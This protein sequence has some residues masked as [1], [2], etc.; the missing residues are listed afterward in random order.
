[1]EM[2]AISFSD[3]RLHHV[4]AQKIQSSLPWKFLSL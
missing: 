3:T 4:I 2:E 1:L